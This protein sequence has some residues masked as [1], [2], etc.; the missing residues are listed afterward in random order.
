LANPA[1][2][3]Y[4]G[5]FW[6]DESVFIEAK[7]NPS[8]KRGSRLIT[9]LVTD[10][11]NADRPKTMSTVLNR[12]YTLEESIAL[13]A[14][15]A[16]VSRA[17]V[18]AWGGNCVAALE[19][20]GN[21]SHC[22]DPKTGAFS[23]GKPDTTDPKTGKVTLGEPGMAHMHIIL[24]GPVGHL[25]L[26]DKVALLGPPPGAL[27]DMRGKGTDEGNKQKEAWQAGEMAIVASAVADELRALAKEATWHGVTC[28]QLRK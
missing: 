14:V 12:D 24:R 2:D 28:V 13:T 8:D 15:T 25:K 16:I 21:N 4:I 10:M 9:Y 19:W 27:F 5:T 23:I 1:E 6:W 18:K 22:Y 7:V 3:A 17:L 11:P 26:K 20:A